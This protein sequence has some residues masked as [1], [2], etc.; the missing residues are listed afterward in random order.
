MIDKDNFEKVLGRMSPQLKLRVT[1]QLQ[2]D[3]SDME[4]DLAFQS[5][6][7]FSPAAVAER[8]PPLKRLLEVRD[9]LRDLLSKADRSE[10]L[11][12]A[13]ERIL[14]DHGDLAGLATSIEKL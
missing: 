8:V 4:V 12:D 2:N 6:E 11:E 3:G 13:L 5:I 1:N 10:Q 7:D 14:R 9:Q